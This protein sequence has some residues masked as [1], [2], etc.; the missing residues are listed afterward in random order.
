MSGFFGGI[1]NIFSKKKGESPKTD[2][3][4]SISEESIN[5]KLN[6]LVQQFQYKNQ[7]IRNAVEGAYGMDSE[8]FNSTAEQ[9]GYTKNVTQ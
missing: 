1:M 4:F 2:L 8:A 6:Q 9:M 7:I 3:I 5:E